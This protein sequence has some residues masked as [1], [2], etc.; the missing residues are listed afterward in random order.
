MEPEVLDYIETGKLVSME[1]EIFPIIINDTNRFFGYKFKGYWMDI[2][3]ISSYIDVHNFLL[4]KNKMDNFI[5]KNCKINGTTKQ[6]SI[7]NNVTIGKNTKLTSTVVLD[8]AEIGD[9][10][11]INYS[12]IGEKS[13]IGS[14]S[15]IKNSVIGGNETIDEKSHLDNIAVWTQPKPEGYPDKQI[16]N[17]IEDK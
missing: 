9:N 12:V 16:G 11:T 1:K 2:G 14:Y 3:R 8:N 17:P 6:S 10:I 4:K 7:G 15:K 5:G 13:K